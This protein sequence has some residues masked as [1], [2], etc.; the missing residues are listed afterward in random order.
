MPLIWL[1]FLCMNNFENINYEFNKS[2]HLVKLWFECFQK[3]F[4]LL[5]RKLIEVGITKSVS[6]MPSI[7]DTDGAFDAH[8]VVLQ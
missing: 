8:I 6:G 3:L 7:N 5:L 1:T 2:R 4:G